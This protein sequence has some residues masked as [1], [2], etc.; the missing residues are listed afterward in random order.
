MRR[1]RETDLHG[2]VV[3]EP[4][5]DALVPHVLCEDARVGDE[6]GD[7][8]AHVVVDLEDLLLVAAELVAVALQRHQHR[9]VA[10]D[11]THTGAALLY[12]LHGVLDLKQAA[13]RRPHCHI[14]IIR[15]AVHCDRLLT[16][17]QCGHDCG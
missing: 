11:G 16:T 6:A 14:R 5:V 12:S 1:A 9:N 3:D 4:M 2:R 15:I 17:T 8:D 13:L 10:A 7:A